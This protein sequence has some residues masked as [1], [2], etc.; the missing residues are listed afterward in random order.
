MKYRL[1]FKISYIKQ[2][3]LND[4]FYDNDYKKTFNKTKEY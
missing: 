1:K 3:L 2:H 4:L